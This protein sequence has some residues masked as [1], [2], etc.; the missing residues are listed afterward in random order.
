VYLTEVYCNLREDEAVGTSSHRGSDAIHLEI[1]P[2][3]SS[4]RPAGVG[5]FLDKDIRNSS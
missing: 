2:P 1:R 4:K 5:E 3:Y